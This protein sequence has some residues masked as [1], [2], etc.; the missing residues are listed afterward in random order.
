MRLGGYE[1]LVYM[2]HFSEKATRRRTGGNRNP[3]NY[4][5][6]RENLI[7]FRL[8]QQGFLLPVW[9]ICSTMGFKGHTGGQNVS[10][11]LILFHQKL[12]QIIYPMVHGEP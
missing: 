2:R 7:F 1:K 12:S 8:A 10:G 9:H 5:V 4:Q 6:Q 11:L 3:N